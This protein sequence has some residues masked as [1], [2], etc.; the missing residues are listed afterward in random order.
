MSLRVATFNIRHGEGLSGTIDLEAQAELIRHLGADVVLLQEVDSGTH[1]SGGVHQASRLAELAGFPY[2]AFGK[3]MDCDGGDY[4]NAILSRFR[5]LEIA[6]IPIPTPDPELPRLLRD[7]TPFYLEQRG[8]LRV[9]VEVEG[10]TVQILCTH[11]GFLEEE[12]PRSARFLLEMI[13]SLEGAVI[14]GGDLNAARDDDEEIVLLR[15]ALTDCALTTGQQQSPTFPADKPT[16]RLDYLFVRGAC[17][18][19]AS[20]VAPTLV[21]DHRPLLADLVMVPD[22]VPAAPAPRVATAN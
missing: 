9:K 1:R 3:N 6:C 7:G 8:V 5:P 12:R 20:V 15:S 13:G 10:E 22:G 17:S 14:L 4:G 11:F 19:V 21:S 2:V 16:L 18:P